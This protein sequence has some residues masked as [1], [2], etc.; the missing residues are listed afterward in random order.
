MV[1]RHNARPLVSVEEYLSTPYE[2][3][4][5]FVDG[6]LVERGLPTQLHGIF[7]LLLGAYLLSFSDQFG[8]AVSSVTR[9][10]VV[11]RRRYRVPDII[12][13]PLPVEEGVI[14]QAPWMIVEIHSPGDRIGNMMTRFQDLELMGVRHILWVDPIEKTLHRYRNGALRTEPA[15]IDLDLPTGVLRCDLQSVFEQLDRTRG[16]A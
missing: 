5:E 6:V 7:Q 3:E 12:V 16:R 10:E 15:V 8:F 4:V 14:T 2:P 11:K 9:T 13:A 1:A